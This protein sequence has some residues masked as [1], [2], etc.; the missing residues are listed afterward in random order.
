MSNTSNNHATI[1]M[2]NKYDVFEFIIFYGINHIHN[3]CIKINVD[4]Q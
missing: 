1:A 3:M 4:I 2:A